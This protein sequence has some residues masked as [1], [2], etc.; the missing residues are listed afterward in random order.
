MIKV[1]SF[2]FDGV[3]VLDSE[4]VFKKTAWEVVFAEHQGRYEF[5]LEE[6]SKMFGYGKAGGRREIM[7]YVIE[8]LGELGDQ[9]DEKLNNSLKLFDDHVQKRI[10]EAGLVGGAVE[11]LE[12]L[13]KRG[14]PLYLNS[15]TA[16]DALRL[17][18]RNLKI[19][20]YFNGIYG[21]ARSKVDN[22]LDVSERESVSPSEILVVGDGDS[23]EKAARETGCQFL[24]V[25][26]R[27]NLW[28]DG[29]KPFP[30]VEYLPDVLQYV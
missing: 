9:L 22:L 18:A 24:G 26:N 13:Q 3:F 14:L 11:M 30:T 12:A 20:N 19:S 8:R 5:L 6:A 23:D 17:S 15:G 1:I 2:D 25:A 16:T 21:S 4:A 10:L 7:R 27:W 29:N 28:K